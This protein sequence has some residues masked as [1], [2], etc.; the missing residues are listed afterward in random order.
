MKPA[1]LESPTGCVKRQLAGP[2]PKFLI[3]REGC[4]AVGGAQ[5]WGW[6]VGGKADLG[7]SHRSATTWQGGLAWFTQPLC[8]SVSSFVK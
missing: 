2:H 5:T 1:V 8:S 6:G 7:S 3:Q 4:V